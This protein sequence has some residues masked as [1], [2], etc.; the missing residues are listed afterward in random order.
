[1]ENEAMATIEDIDK[2]LNRPQ[3]E[4]RFVARLYELCEAD[5][6]RP[7]KDLKAYGIPSLIRMCL[8]NARELGE[9]LN[10]KAQD[11]ITYIPPDDDS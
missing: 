4:V 8:R 3:R 10:I 9:A 2:Y 7:L 11:Y 6:G 5:R 1:M